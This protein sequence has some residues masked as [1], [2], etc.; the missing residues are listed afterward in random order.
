MNTQLDE[1]VAKERSKGVP[2]DKIRQELLSKGWDPIAVHRSIGSVTET[3][4]KPSIHLNGST[5][6]LIVGLSLI[7]IAALAFFGYG[8]PDLSPLSR[9]VLIAVPNLLLF[10]IGSYLAKGEALQT[11]KETTHAA[12]HIMLPITIGVFLYQFGFY[13]SLD[14]LLMA[15]SVLIAFPLYLYSAIYKKHSYGNLLVSLGAVAIAIFLMS[16]SIL[17]GWRSAGLLTV[18]SVLT[19]WTAFRQKQS[20]QPAY[21]SALTST[22]AILLIISFPTLISDL[23]QLITTDRPTVAIIEGL[24]GGGGLLVLASQFGA[25]FQPWS[26]L[27]LFHQRLMIVIGALVVFLPLM[28]GSSEAVILAVIAVVAAAIIV[29]IGIE[30]QVK[31]LTWLGIVGGALSLLNVLFSTIDHLSVVLVMF[32]LGFAAILLSI[33]FARRGHQPSTAVAGPNLK[34]GFIDDQSAGNL[35]AT[36]GEAPTL[37]VILARIILAIILFWFI[38]FIII[39]SLNSSHNNGYQSPT[40]PASTTNSFI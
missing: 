31:L 17:D 2:D 26:R 12:G 14:D 13:K 32:I 28:S 5:V 10:L 39:G 4:P 23:A 29:I 16:D 24:I 22:G 11:V 15:Y 30:S 6:L 25:L 19:L 38:E 8:W 7:F 36:T 37:F 3:A 33:I 20:A 35:R 34:V 1:Y 27:E 18:V 40:S 9:F 21:L